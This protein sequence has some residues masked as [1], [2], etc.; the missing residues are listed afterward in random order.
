LAEGQRQ[1]LSDAYQSHL[2]CRYGEQASAPFA[3]HGNA[4]EKQPNTRR[5]EAGLKPHERMP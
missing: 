2:L 4:E 5:V 1:R 3:F